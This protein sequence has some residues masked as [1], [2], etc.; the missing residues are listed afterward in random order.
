MFGCS[1]KTMADDENS[2][3]HSRNHFSSDWFQVELWVSGDCKMSG[4][5]NWIKATVK[6]DSNATGKIYCCFLTR[7]QTTMLRSILSLTGHH[8][9]DDHETAQTREGEKMDKTS[10]CLR[11]HMSFIR[12]EMLVSLCLWGPAGLEE[13][14]LSQAA[15]QTGRR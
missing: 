4:N 15:A 2:T 14:L 6:N 12:L 9:Q 11:G 8:Q 10:L 13:V 5:H 3:A 7:L 1:G